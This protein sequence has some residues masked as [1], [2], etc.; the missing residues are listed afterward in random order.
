MESLGIPATNT[1]VAASFVNNPATPF[2]YSVSENSFAGTV[3]DP[4]TPF[5]FEMTE[6][7]GAIFNDLN[8]NPFNYSVSSNAGVDDIEDFCL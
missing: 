3:V 7:A 1:A 4:S 8:A 2:S 5:A 6:D